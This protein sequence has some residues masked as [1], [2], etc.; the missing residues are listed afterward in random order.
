MAYEKQNWADGDDGGT[1]LSAAR[2]NHMEDGIAEVAN[3][4]V[5]TYQTFYDEPSDS[6]TPYLW[7]PASI[8]IYVNNVVNQ[9]VGE[10]HPE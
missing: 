5:G 3:L 10:Y 4:P 7:T 2:L 8:V 6:E 9:R 1:P